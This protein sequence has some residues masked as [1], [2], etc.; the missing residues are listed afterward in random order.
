MAYQKL[1]VRYGE[2]TLKG[3]NRSMFE[4]ILVDNIKH[5]L[6]GQDYA[7]ITQAYGRIYIE[8]EENWETIAKKL[9]KVFGI[10]SLSPVIETE[11]ELKAIKKASLKLMEQF[12]NHSFKVNAR[13]PNKNFSL[14]SP[15]ICREIGGFLLQ[16]IDN[17]SVD[18]HQPEIE[19]EIEIRN[20]GVYLF[21]QSLPGLGG[22]PVG[23]SSKA[24]LLLSGGIDSP[25]AGY[26]SLKRGVILEGVHFHSY[27]LTSQRSKEKVFEL[28]RIL[29]EY[30]GNGQLKLWVV[31][32]TEIQ[33]ALHSSKFPDLNITLMRR[34]MLRIGE[35]LA[36]REKALAM[37][38]GDSLGQ[39]ASQT[40]ESIAVINEVTNIPIF[41]PLIGF[42]KQEIIDLAKEIGTYSTSILPYEDC[43]TV[44]VP[45]HPATRPRLEQ[46]LVAESQ[47]DL[48]GLIEEA[49]AKTELIRLSKTVEYF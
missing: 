34:M 23:S 1:L 42:D 32:F 47:F 19:L 45:K 21:N 48:D 7:K 26:L 43:C 29:T 4:R 49:I 33:K 46:V 25:V 37:V 38:T 8:S 22:M 40:M 10:V 44:F 18:V 12:S 41:R 6:Q 30:T 20:E 24:L 36:Q 16:N 27:P 9:Q 31:Y 15:E 28:G 3:K 5:A 39:V 2:I 17:L 13:R 14:T 35:K 11:L